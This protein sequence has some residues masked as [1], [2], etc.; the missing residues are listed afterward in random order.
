[1]GVN[2]SYMGTKKEL[3]PAVSEV[4]QQAQSGILL[5]AF[6]GMCSVGEQVA[7]E[8]QIWSNDIQV[9]ASEIARALF[10][11]R[12]EPP[13]AIHA[14]NLH[15]DC[16][17]LHRL[18]LSKICRSPLAIEMAMVE[19]SSFRAFQKHSAL[20]SKCLAADAHLLRPKQNNLFTKTYANTY[21]GLQQAIDAD[22][23]IKS[24]SRSAADGRISLDQKRWLTIALGRALLKVANSTGHFAQYLK[25]KSRSF[26]RYQTLRRRSLWAEWLFSIG[27]LQA[28]GT[29]EWRMDNRV[30]N[31]DSL[32]L[33]PKLRRSR[34][35]PAV[36]YADPPYTDDQYSRYYHLLDTLVLYDYPEV[37]GVGLYRAQRFSTP[38]SLKSK[39]VA[40]F[41]SLV[42]TCASMD[43]DLVLSYPNNGLMHEVGAEPR[44]ILKKHYRKVECCRSLPH[45]HSTFGASK[46]PA[47][48]S[49]T[50]LIYLATS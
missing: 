27:E 2:I 20:L 8:R 1:M 18:A 15:Y 12:D 4:I 13:S 35:R 48:S 6:A 26:K 24:M 22:A 37:T 50:E 41:E 33:L 46:G 19:V 30:F 5:D 25:P 23:I 43:A 11:S 32:L 39:T 3:A 10:T 16:F 28:I 31:E 21:F 7:S 42:R 47:Q 36:V 29:S 9:F 34:T 44:V 17:E 38:F 40:A 49:V 45:R 14:A